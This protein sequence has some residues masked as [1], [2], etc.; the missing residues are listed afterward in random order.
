M[1]FSLFP[2]LSEANKSRLKWDQQ[3]LARFTNDV[4]AIPNLPKQY[5]A[6]TMFKDWD[7]FVIRNG[8]GIVQE[9][10]H[11]DVYTKHVR[12]ISLPSH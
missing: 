2:F 8:V 9:H 1:S 7:Y 4:V 5:P 11:I 12:P 10:L 6:V 3:G